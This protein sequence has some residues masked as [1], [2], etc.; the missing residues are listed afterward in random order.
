MEN[1]KVI[2]N[3]LV[4]SD[5]RAMRKICGLSEKSQQ[6]AE[7]GLKNTLYSIAFFK[8]EKHIAMGRIIGDGGTFAQIVDICVHPDEQGKGLGKKIM[9]HLMIFANQ[10]PKTCYISLIA[11][12]YASFL[13]EKFGFKEVMPKSKG[14]ALKIE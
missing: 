4:V 5:Y 9:E 14:M 10:L 2:E 11:D 12:G 1:F 7:I 6:A 8:E 13:Y 3:H